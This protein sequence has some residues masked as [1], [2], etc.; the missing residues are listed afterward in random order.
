MVRAGLEFLIDYDRATGGGNPAIPHRLPIRMGPFELDRSPN[1]EFLLADLGFIDPEQLGSNHPDWQYPVTFLYVESKISVL[2]SGDPQ[3]EADNT[4]ESLEWLLRLFQPGDL[5]VRRHDWMWTVGEEEPKLMLFFKFRPV[6][7]RAAALYDRPAYPLD[8]ELLGSFAK[9]LES[10]WEATCAVSD[11]L[12]TALRRFGSSYEKRDL[13]D[14]L[15]DLVVAMEAL[16]G[17]GQGSVAYKVALRGA[18]WLHPRGECRVKAFREIKKLYDLRSR[19]IHGGKPKPL[20]K[21]QVDELEETVRRSML[22]FLD[23]QIEEGHT[24]E[25]SEIDELI[26]EG[27]I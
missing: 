7:A 10:Y 5:S 22:K 19:A 2:D 24:P 14:R 12:K 15:V 8:D 13:E 21:D 20:Q 27:A 17:D 16:F 18:S 26:M 25:G 1:A 6:K 11:S 3:A 23:K 9:F 4:F